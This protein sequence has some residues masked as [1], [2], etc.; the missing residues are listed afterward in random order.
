MKNLTKFCGVI[1][2]WMVIVFALSLTGCAITVP[3]SSVRPPT[4]D[5]SNVQRLAIRDFQ[6]KSGVGGVFGAQLTQYLTEQAKQRITATGKFTI[7]ATTDPNADG[8]FAGEIRS[9]KVDQSQE[10]R[11][12]TD[13]DGNTYIETT[14]RR[15]VSLEFQYNVISS[16]TNMPVGTV[17]K[18]GSLSDYQT[19]LSRLTDQLT[20]AKR[21]VDSQLGTLRQ[22][23]VPTLVQQSVTLRN[24]KSKDKSVKQMIK[25]AQAFVKSRNYEEAIRYFEEIGTETARYNADILRRSIAS[26][27]AARAQLAALFSDTGGLAEKAAKNAVNVLYSNLTQ[28]G[29]VIIITKETSTDRQRLDYVVDQIDKTIIQDKKLTIVD[30]SNQNLIKAEQD[31]QTS[32]EVSEKSMVSI[33]KQLGAQYIVFCSISGQASTRQFNLRIASVETSQILDKQSFDL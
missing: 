32:G 20:L 27:A 24:E 8:V 13:K 31:F 2:I 19:E 10:S 12:L 11:E 1:A 15:D 30:R 29:T 25:E 22:D 21:I 28:P 5:T 14:Y 6:N 26:D 3:I 33:G 7:V 18:S 4:I 23:I 9:I 17:T 16:R